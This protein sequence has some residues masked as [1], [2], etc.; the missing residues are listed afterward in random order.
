MEQ[1]KHDLIFFLVLC[2]FNMKPRDYI[3]FQA[4]VQVRIIRCLH[5]SQ[6]HFP[7]WICLASA[8]ETVSLALACLHPV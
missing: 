1:R 8:S 2:Y 3:K 5:R 4:A 6:Q 7:F